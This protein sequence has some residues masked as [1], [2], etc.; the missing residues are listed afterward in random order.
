LNR[1]NFQTD[2]AFRNSQYSITASD[3]SSAPDGNTGIN[4]AID[5]LVVT[6]GST[7]QYIL[8]DPGDMTSFT[9]L[10]YAVSRKDQFNNLVTL[11]DNTVYLY[12]TSSGP[13]SFY[14]A[15]INGNVI[16]SIVISNGN[17]SANFWY[18]DEAPGTWTITASDNATAPDGTSGITDGTDSVVVT[19]APIV[20]TKFVILNPGN[21]TVDAPVTVTVQAQDNDGNLD[22]SYQSDV[23]LDASGSAT[24]GGLVDIVN[25]VGTI[26]ISDVA[27][28]DVLLSLTDSQT[29]GL[30]V[31]STAHIIFSAGAIAQFALDNPG[32]MSAGTR[33]GYTVTRKDQFGNLVTLSATLVYLYGLPAAI[34]EKFYD[35]SS[36][37]S[38]ITFV[39]IPDG[40]SSAQFWFYDELAETS[41]VVTSDNS[42][43][44]DGTAGIDDV[45][46][47][48]IV[49]AGPIAKFILNNPGDMTSFTRLGYTVS[50]Q[51]QFNN[52]VTSG[53]T[54]AYLYTSST[55]SNARF[56]DSATAGLVV[57]SI[58]IDDTHSS[59]NFWYY[60]ETAGTWVITVSDGTPT[61]NG[62]TGVLDD[63]DTVIV[64]NIPIVAT[65]FVILPPT[66][67]QISV[68]VLVTVQAQDNNGN[69]DTTYQ[70]DVTLVASGSATGD[71]LVAITNGTGT[72][73]IND[74]TDE[75]VLL[76]L[77]D[78]ESSGLTVSSTGQIHFSTLPQSFT[79]SGGGGIA[80]P[81]GKVTFSGF[82][83]PGAS[84]SIAAIKETQNIIKQDTVS[85]ADGS[86]EITFTGLPSGTHAFALLVSDKDKR[87]AQSKVYDL[88]LLDE[89]SIL[90]VNNIM[91]SPTV[92]FPRPTITK[93]DFLAIVGYAT[94]LHKLLIEVDGKAIDTNITA[95]TNGE[96]KYLYNTALLDYGSHTI[97]ALQ[98]SGGGTK[99]E[100]SPQKVFFTT[101]LS[102]PKTDFNNDGKL[103]ISDWSIFLSRWLAADQATRLSNDLNNDGK[104]N[105][106]DFSIFVR[107]LRQ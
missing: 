94:P 96:Y 35:A 63:A 103:N 98:S 86:F 34:T 24:G 36:G 18:Y 51:D 106:S 15:S 100:F 91:V 7:S 25:G 81:V 73:N 11:G 61:P 71:G 39:N 2:I 4:D 77:S 46:D 62:T 75:T 54:L 31:S 82:A 50:R 87:I 22:T 53:V 95:G 9:R 90:D 32:D 42:S 58:A 37:G 66:D 70:T 19:S 69:V 29:T 78:S 55:G 88:N 47:Q 6:A 64:S 89:N 72:L 104:V 83:Y 67:S 48:V 14:D 30:D 3:N 102:V 68:P 59:A 16:T 52:L 65:R 27:T 12:T 21:G 60:D 80:I 84:L 41:S 10:G 92:G 33:L 56:Y 99:S 26:N 38:V 49:S 93:G 107:T 74:T 20:A 85:S 101:N 40:S 45:S 5:S 105:A 23:T 13:A 1:P 76:S 17:S 57:T 44:P 79:S 8:N 28:E 97:R 43:A